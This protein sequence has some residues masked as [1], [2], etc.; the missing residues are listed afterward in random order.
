MTLTRMT[1]SA[2]LG[3]GVSAATDTLT[4]TGTIGGMAVIDRVARTVPGV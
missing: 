2:H 3:R 1:Q 4:T